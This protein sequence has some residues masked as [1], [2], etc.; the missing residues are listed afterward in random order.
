MATLELFGK[1]EMYPNLNNKKYFIYKVDT[2]EKEI[3]MNSNFKEFIENQKKN[4]K[5]KHY[6]GID[7]EFNK[8]SKDTKDVALMQINLENDSNIGNI[9]IFNPNYIDTTILLLLITN[10]N[11]IKILHGAESLDIPYLFNQ[12]L[13]TKE[14]VDNFCKN[15]YDTKFLCEYM[16]I[17]SNNVS[18]SIYSILLTNNII[19]DSILERLNKIE[20]TMG[21]VYMVEFDI[22]KMT[23]DMLNYC[24][25]DVLFLPELIKKFDRKPYNNIIPQISSLVNKYKRNIEPEFIE[26]NQRINNFNI[27][28]MF[29]N[30]NRI[31]LNQIWEV[32][33]NIMD[34][35]MKYF[36]KLKQINYF[37]NFF[38]IITKFVI[39]Y[40]LIQYF[41]IYSNSMNYLIINKNNIYESS[42]MKICL[43]DVDS[44]FVW[45]YNYPEVSRI[46]M[47]INKKIKLEFD[48]L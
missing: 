19:N 31:M 39:Y 18:C 7:F 21:P 35:D 27:Y 15:F 10:T 2:K 9:F 13:V 28:Y 8:V 40:N 30:D 45:L 24:L 47:Q 44:Y 11:I 12:L 48:K 3:F 22:Y 46:I 6:I 5:E 1:D 32:Y 25:Y 16:K 20:E 41:K 33:Y 37:K 17:D 42:S 43:E 34:D 14:N 29:D 36:S 23:D 38:E 26:L 4:L